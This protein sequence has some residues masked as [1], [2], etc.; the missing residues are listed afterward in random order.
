MRQ[1]RDCGF[2]RK[3]AKFFDWRSDGTIV[4]TDS[5]RTRSQITFLEV[6]ELETLFKDLSDTIGLDIDRI[7]IGA[8]KNI[9]KAL[10]ANLPIRHMKRVP[11]WL[12]PRFVA[13]QLVKLI[14]NDIAGLGDGIVSLD[15]YVAGRTMVVRFA[16]PVLAP[17]MVGSV[18][19][20]YESVEDM[21]S[22]KA[23]YGIEGGDLVI[24]MTHAPEQ[25]EAEERLKLEEVVEGQGPLRYDRCGYCGVPREAARTWRWDL[26]RGI[27][28][29][30]RTGSRE[31]VVAVQSVNAMLRELENELGEDVP[32][33][34]YDHQKALTIKKLSGAAVDD[35]ASFVKER[36]G[37]M[38]LRGLG[39]PSSFE[40]KEPTLTVEIKNAYNQ[41]LYAAKLAAVIET[42]TSRS[43]RIEWQSREPHDDRYTIT[44]E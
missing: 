19:G 27:I 38:A 21:P 11:D 6:S 16:N 33:L 42:A 40:W 18:S 1:C 29:N 3:F 14:A 34:V 13:R 22:S 28:T 15:E 24:R 32:A 8:Q 23:E 17:L 39:Y 20:I 5:T 44:V 41:D 10:Y 35:V 30:K 43:S 4:S 7:F 2:P 26:S 25:A 37:S 12:R 31:A 36:I 9:G